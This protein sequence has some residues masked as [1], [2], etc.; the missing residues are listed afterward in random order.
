MYY[1]EQRKNLSEFET[2]LSQSIFR[3]LGMETEVPSK[4]FLMTPLRNPHGQ[5]DLA[6]L[7]RLV[8]FSAKV[9]QQVSRETKHYGVC[10]LLKPYN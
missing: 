5:M 4:R 2:L 10:N 1:K 6:S 9:W 3:C 8:D 7:L